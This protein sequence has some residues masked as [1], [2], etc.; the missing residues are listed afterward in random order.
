MPNYGGTSDSDK[1]QT[2]IHSY[3]NNGGYVGFTVSKGY[4]NEH[5]IL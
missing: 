3:F 1:K 5:S 4:Y 2:S